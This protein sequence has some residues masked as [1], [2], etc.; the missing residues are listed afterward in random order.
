MF[1]SLLD[2]L[3]AFI[4]SFRLNDYDEIAD[5]LMD[6]I[7][8]VL[9]EHDPNFDIEVYFQDELDEETISA[10]EESEPGATKDGHEVIAFTCMND[11][12]NFDMVFALEAVKRFVTT[13][14][15]F[16]LKDEIRGVARH[17]AYHVRQYRY[18]YEKGGL[19]AL[20]RLCDDLKHVE[21]EENAL[22][23]G[24]YLFQFF[25]IEQDFSEDFAPYLNKAC[26]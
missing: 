4:N 11:D 14:N 12:G 3:F 1:R 6:G 7:R 13:A 9:D 16:R 15:P 20:D 8:E 25:G 21:Y 5:T 23:I 18:V 19:E 22:E 2:K 24:A 10:V 26:A 17:E